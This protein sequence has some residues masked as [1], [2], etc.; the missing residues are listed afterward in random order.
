MELSETL[1]R[2]KKKS[3]EVSIKEHGY[4]PYSKKI[5]RSIDYLTSFFEKHRET[6]IFEITREKE[7][8]VFQS[9]KSTMITCKE[10]SLED[11]SKTVENMMEE[12]TVEVENMIRLLSGDETEETLKIFIHY[13]DDKNNISWTQSKVKV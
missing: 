9:H 1:S 6:I 2:L 7:I 12:K 13:V 8:Q 5:E 11:F 3:I 10:T 4:I